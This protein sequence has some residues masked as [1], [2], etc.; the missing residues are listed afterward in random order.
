MCGQPPPAVRCR[1][2]AIEVSRPL[3]I[4]DITNDITL[5]HTT[6]HNHGVHSAPGAG[7]RGHR[8]IAH[9]EN[10]G[11]LPSGVPANFI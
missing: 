6:S 5:Y 9:I 1:S 8:W 3:L 10:E 4:N 2:R 11:W 7:K